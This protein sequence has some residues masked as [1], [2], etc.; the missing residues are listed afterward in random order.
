ML[1]PVMMAVAAIPCYYLLHK[2]VTEYSVL[3][4]ISVIPAAVVIWST[5]FCLLVAL[6]KAI[7]LRRLKT[8]EGTIWG[9]QFVFWWFLTILVAVADQVWL[10]VT[11]GTIFYI[12]WLRLMGASIGRGNIR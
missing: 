10:Q 6:V 8:M 9:I 12:W 3:K 4:T 11:N 7:L 5:L 2:M 1:L